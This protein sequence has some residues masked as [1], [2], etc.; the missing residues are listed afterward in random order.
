MQ[1]KWEYCVI[2]GIKVPV[3]AGF[4]PHYPKL[5]YFSL[6]GIETKIDLG[7]SAASKRPESWRKASEA[8]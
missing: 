6:N 7:N 3:I 4:N 5:T 1:Q 8:E 2:T